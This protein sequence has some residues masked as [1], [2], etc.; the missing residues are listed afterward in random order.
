MSV[1]IRFPFSG[2]VRLFGRVLHGWLVVLLVAS[3]SAGE[4]V[5]AQSLRTPDLNA[6]YH[7][8]ETAWRSGGSLLEAKARVDRV[9]RE[10]PDDVEARKLRA[11]VLLALGHPREAM[12]D[13]RHAAQVRPQD[14]E[15]HLLVAEAARL[16][17]E[18]RVAREML[19]EAGRL[20]LDDADLHVRLSWS[21]QQLGQLHKA[22]AF[23]RTAHA[24][25]PSN[26]A[27]FYQLARVFI[28]QGRS[29]DAAAILR[30]GLQQHLL[31]PAA[32]AADTLLAPLADHEA[33]HDL[34]R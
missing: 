8:A 30:R 10:L 4:A 3:M 5:V 22:E 19:D 24:L 18:R 31:T 14:G 2:P 23:A 20:V 15:A 28:V 7:R 29:D 25:D 21:A 27:A 12:M 17:G 9:L 13:A 26:P 6:Q 32:V 16:C 34:M 33:L 1:E 11:Q